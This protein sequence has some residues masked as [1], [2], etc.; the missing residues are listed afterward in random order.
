[1][2]LA[3]IAMAVSIACLLGSVTVVTVPWWR[4]RRHRTVAS[5]PAVVFPAPPPTPPLL[6]SPE[7]GTE[8]KGPYYVP[9]FGMPILEVYSASD[10]A[11]P[12]IC[13]DCKK[14]FEDGQRFY[15]IP[16]SDQAPGSGLGVHAYCYGKAVS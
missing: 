8:I 15:F 6:L 2:T 4:K 12:L 7:P 9:N 5:A 13:P 16:I 10:Y 3:I 11:E 14:S 1:M